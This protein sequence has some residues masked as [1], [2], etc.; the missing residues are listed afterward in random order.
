MLASHVSIVNLPVRGPEKPWSTRQG[1]AR[2]RTWAQVMSSHPRMMR[3]SPAN[4]ET[5]RG[6]ESL[7]A[8]VANATFG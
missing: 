4:A 6:L 7:G 8:T 2:E 3:K 5:A 1:L